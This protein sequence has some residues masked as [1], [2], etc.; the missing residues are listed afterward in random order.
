MTSQ[1]LTLDDDSPGSPKMAPVFEKEM[2]PGTQLTLAPTGEPA[3]AVSGQLSDWFQSHILQ[4]L[5]TML[6]DPREVAAKT[7]ALTGVAV[8]RDPK[9]LAAARAEFERRRGP[10]F[11]Y[12]P[13]V[14]NRAPPLDYRN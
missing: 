12:Q 11:Q 10:D 4:V 9:L 2:L 14:G 7:L 8:F 5:L 6:A 1:R 13:L 3:A